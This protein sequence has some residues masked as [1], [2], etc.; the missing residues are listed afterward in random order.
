[1]HGVHCWHWLCPP[2]T[3]LEAIASAALTTPSDLSAATLACSG[4]DPS[5]K[6]K[7]GWL[8]C[9]VFKHELSYAIAVWIA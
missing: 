4:K 3:S 1:M 8:V 9:F 7:L 6:G 5:C 2:V